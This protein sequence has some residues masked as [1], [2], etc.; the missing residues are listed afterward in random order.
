MFPDNVDSI[1]KWVLLPE[2]VKQAKELLKQLK[3]D[4][5]PHL[6][7]SAFIV[8]SDPKG[9]EKELYYSA[10]KVTHSCKINSIEKKLIEDYIQL[11]KLWSQKDKETTTD[12]L[13]KSYHQLTVMQM[14]TPNK[15][16][17][18][19]LQD[20]KEE[21]KQMIYGVSGRA[22]I[23]KM[24]QI[25]PVVIDSSIA[26]KAYWDVL[27][28]EIAESPPKLVMLSKLLDQIKTNLLAIIP[29]KTHLHK[30]FQE[31]FDLTIFKQLVEVNHLDATYIGNL[32]LYLIS[33]IQKLQSASEDKDTTEWQEQVQLY[34][35]GHQ[36]Q[37]LAEFLS[38]FFKKVIQKVGTI[39][40]KFEIGRAHV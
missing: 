7:L 24:L 35:N 26:E 23:T 5:S 29:E 39:Q 18:E 11:F 38:N 40:L 34:F 32:C 10:L 22:G 6:F 20:K 12:E 28:E 19:T 36:Q 33:T 4:A 37:T 13:I 30:A 21:L 27:K 25:A 3:I 8:S 15:T 2:T 9:F 16:F 1:E 31:E 14:N 17:K